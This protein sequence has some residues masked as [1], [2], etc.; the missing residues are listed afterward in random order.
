MFVEFL[1]NRFK[2]L[3]AMVDK[4]PDG[5]TGSRFMYRK[6]YWNHFKEIDPG[7]LAGWIFSYEEKGMRMKA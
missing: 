2:A 1:P 3:R 7:K 6:E 4:I 5:D